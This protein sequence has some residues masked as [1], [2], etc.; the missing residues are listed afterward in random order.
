MLKVSK[1]LHYYTSWSLILHLFCKNTYWLAYFVKY[2][3]NAIAILQLLIGTNNFLSTTLI[4]LS[5]ELPFMF[6]EMKADETSKMLLGISLLYYVMV[7]GIE[8]IYDLYMNKNFLYY[9]T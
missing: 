5:H 2:V 8:F 1:L 3:G 4:I 6:K 7:F 9:V